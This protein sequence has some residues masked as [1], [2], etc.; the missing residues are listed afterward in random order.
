MIGRELYNT[1]RFLT[2]I[3]KS[4]KIMAISAS[5]LSRI[6]LPTNG[7]LKSGRVK[8]LEI[9]SESSSNTLPTLGGASLVVLPERSS[10]CISGT[11]KS[12]SDI[13]E[14]LGKVAKFDINVLITG[15]TGTGKELAA[16]TLHDLSIRNKGP[17]V[18]VNCGAIPREL[19]ESELFGHTRGSFTG[20][21]KGREGLFKLA[22][23]GTIFLDE[24]S[25]LEE[26]LL[27]KLIRTVK[28]GRLTKV[29]SD[30]EVEVD[31]RV[32]AA[33]NRDLKSVIKDKN[34]L[35]ELLNS[36]GAFSV[37]MPPLR[38]HSEDIEDIALNLLQRNLA[39]VNS[40]TV[41]GIT[42]DAIKLLQNYNW[43]GNVR[44]LENV[45]K[46]AIILTQGSIIQDS[47]IFIGD[48]LP[49]EKQSEHIRDIASSNAT[50]LIS[51]E[52][53]TGVESI[54]KDI[55][56]LSSR[57]SGPCIVVDCAS[58]PVTLAQS[59]LFGH[60]KGAFTNATS[61]HIGYFE[62]A[63]NGTLVLLGVDLLPPGIQSM[64]LRV[65]Q[66]GCINR[67]GENITRKVNPRI[68][69]T[70]YH[71]LKERTFRE[72]LYNRLNTMPIKIPP[73][74]ERTG[75]IAELA[76]Q[77]LDD[78]NRKN[79]STFWL[80]YTTIKKL[81]SYSWTGNDDELKNVIKR[82]VVKVALEGGTGIKP[83]HIEEGL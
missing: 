20:A 76:K 63:N 8:G 78:L 82:A 15:E 51:G 69:A 36:I 37:Q 47:D 66:E 80:Y 40:K 38:E 83:K 14:V 10:P 34:L 28:A 1:T 39:L 3:F 70:C 75:N 56:D 57:S 49:S 18:A 43:P 77:F 30:N 42:H 29:G 33:S 11:G 50:I 17:F 74:R 23:N 45:I 71:D 67:V 19:I 54:A 2:V 25:E 55:H 81:E 26:K 22:D 72:D 52:A 13:R 44:E 12:L 59:E 58:I 48:F 64:L 31:V 60:V 46:R 4:N 27:Y 62:A 32:I 79:M 16:R 41:N 21:I 9:W 68:I 24:I 5:R 53:G 7:H 73:L 65:L 6:L 61:D 35:I